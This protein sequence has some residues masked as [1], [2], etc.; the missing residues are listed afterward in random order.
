VH[1]N[2]NEFINVDKS[3]VNLK[4]LKVIFIVNVSCKNKMK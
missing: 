3:A 4:Q 1:T 2:L